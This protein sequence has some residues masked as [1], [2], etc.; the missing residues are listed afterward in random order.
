MAKAKKAPQKKAAAS[1][2][3]R[4]VK[5]ASALFVAL[6]LLVVLSMLL[7]SVFTQTPQVAVPVPTAVPIMVPTTT[8]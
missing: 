5:I 4:G 1:T 3:N 8:P 7:S 6:G 2:Q